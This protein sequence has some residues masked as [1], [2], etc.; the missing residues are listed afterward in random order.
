MAGRENQNG[1]FAAGVSHRT[2]GDG[3]GVSQGYGNFPVCPGLA[4]GDLPQGCPDRTLIGGTVGFQRNGES[5]QSAGK[6]RGQLFGKQG[7]CT[8]VGSVGQAALRQ[9]LKRRQGSQH[10]V[11]QGSG[12]GK[13]NPRRRYGKIRQSRAACDTAGCGNVKMFSHDRTP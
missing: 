1:I 2:G 7:Q 12:K 6:I 3:T 8:A 11:R 5:G 13:G 9:G 10:T 4:V